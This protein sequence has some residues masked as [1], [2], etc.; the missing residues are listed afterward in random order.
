MAALAEYAAATGERDASY[1]AR[2]FLNGRQLERY[3]VEKG[4]FTGGR[5]SITIPMKELQQGEKTGCGWN[6]REAKGPSTYPH[7]WG[8]SFLPRRLTAARVWRSS[9]RCTGSRRA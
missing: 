1:P 3:L 6:G 8:T 9:G 7:D 4:T 2:L 5:P